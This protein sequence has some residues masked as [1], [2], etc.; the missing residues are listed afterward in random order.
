MKY[1]IGGENIEGTFAIRE[2]VKK[3]VSKLERHLIKK[4]AA[5][6]ETDVMV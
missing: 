3:N 6:A 5:N 2:Y 1:N 4:E